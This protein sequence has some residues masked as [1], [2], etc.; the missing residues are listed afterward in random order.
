MAFEKLSKTM[1]NF[2]EF[3][4][5]NF[6]GDLKNSLIEWQVGDD[7]INKQEIIDILIATE[8]INLFKDSKF[9]G[10][11][12]YFYLCSDIKDLRIYCEKAGVVFD[13]SNIESVAKK[14]A[15]ITFAEN[16]LYKYL[17]IDEFG[18]N[19]YSFDVLQDN[20]PIER[21]CF[22]GE[23]FFELYDYQYMIKQQTIHDIENPEKDLYRILI[24]MPTGT[25][26]TKTTMHII[27]HYL[28]FVTKGNGLI[29]WIAHTNEL[30]QQAYET[31]VNVWSH[32]GTFDTN[33]YK[34]W[35]GYP[36]EF[37]NGI[38]FTSIQS[39]MKKEKTPVFDYI[40]THASLIVF[41]EAHK[42][43]ARQYGRCVNDL[44]RYGNEYGKKFIGLTAT[45]GRTTEVSK[46]NTIFSNDYDHIIGIDVDLV[47]SITLNKNEA[48]NYSGSKDV[49]RYFQDK[50]ILSIIKRELLDYDEVDPDIIKRIEKELRNKNDDFSKDLLEVISK[51]TNRNIRIVEE[52]QRLNDNNIPTI[53]FACSLKHAKMLSAILKLNGIKNSLVHGDMDRYSRQKAISDFKNRDNDINVIVN[54][55]ILTTG[56]DS[57]NIKCVFITRPTKSV[58]LYSQMI[59]RGLRGPKMGGNAECLLID[60]KENLMSFN[61]NDAFKHF[62]EYWRY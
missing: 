45:P 30:L 10:F 26:K 60:V 58:I 40:D 35:N 23:K 3:D 34:G 50:K 41:D 12:E 33:I 46:E 17:L 16:E 47:N 22:S 32:L 43:G 27:S 61:E 42:S 21:L 55:E 15:N 1:R 6:L 31:F 11:K 19:D 18:L 51:N 25:G 59:G 2:D 8:G 62:D 38:L 52:L 28:N 37:E 48:E 39:L 49:I 44:M 9:K 13:E 57:T 54:Y 29:V 36:D 4:L 56:F 14:L 53:V 20:N 5:K 7:G 24:H